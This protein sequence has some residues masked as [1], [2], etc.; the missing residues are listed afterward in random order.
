MK[1]LTACL[2]VALAL[3]AG[4]GRGEEKRWFLDLY[5]G[6]AYTRGTNLSVEDEP[7]IKVDMSKGAFAGGGRVGYWL[8]MKGSI[9]ENKLG[10]GLDISA[11][12]PQTELHTV[13]IPS[14][15]TMVRY[16]VGKFE[17]YLGI[18]LAF[19]VAKTSV[20]TGMFSETVRM[21]GVGIQ[22][23]AGIRI[24]RFLLEYR[25]LRGYLQSKDLSKTVEVVEILGVPPLPVVTSERN[26]TVKSRMNITSHFFVVG[27]RF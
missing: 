11:F 20:H 22:I 5:T 7:S 13:A 16:P 8:E 24:G 10:L 9:L 19:P 1:K 23:P 4:E 3:W 12:N 26:E 25:F 6:N 14:L 15:F 2:V 27:I 17:P 21:R 18:G